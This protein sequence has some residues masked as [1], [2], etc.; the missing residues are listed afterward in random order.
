MIDSE[1]LISRNLDLAR[2]VAWRWSRK[3]GMAYDDMEALAFMGLVK[4]VRR[5]DPLRINPRSG[6]P[7]SLSTIACPFIQGEILHWFR[8]K[9][10]HVRYP[11]RWREVG[12]KARR[13]LEQGAPVD[14]V[15]EAC[16]ISAEELE[17]MLGAMAGT[18]ELQD[19]LQG[20]PDAE[21][22][23]DVLAP[24]W[25][26]LQR[27]WGL[28][29]PG[30][31]GLVERYWEG[32][33]RD[34]FPHRSLRALHNCVAMAA[35]NRPVITYRQQELAL[36]VASV[37]PKK[38]ERQPRGRSRDELEALPAVQLALLVPGL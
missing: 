16:G 4:G 5:Y 30:D 14:A 2:S 3:S 13:M 25:G 35:G 31:R 18:T 19:H 20:Q 38:R 28:L 32:L 21:V 23:E 8:D 9:G 11:S 34:G 24:L 26:L 17:E 7:Y 36:T 37:T 15:C 6:R 27:A 10:Y 22:E 12:P 33:S 1:D 29:H